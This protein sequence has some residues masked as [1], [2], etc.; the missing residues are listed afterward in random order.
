MT[1]KQISNPGQAF[2]AGAT[3]GTLSGDN[4]MTQEVAHLLNG[5]G[6]TLYT[7]DIVCMDATGTQAILST[8][9]G[10]PTQI[11]TVGGAEQWGSYYP[12]GSS[13]IN[14]GTIG[15]QAVPNLLSPNV[16]A[17]MGFTNG[18]ATVTYAGA[19]ATDLGKQLLPA[20]NSTTNAN[21]Q[22]LTIIAV[23]AGVNY[24]VSANFNGTTGTFSTLLQSPPSSIGPGW[25]PTSIA[26][27]EQVPVV[28]S[29]L[30]RVNINAVAATVAKD[31]ISVGNASVVGA[32]TA[33][34]A[35]VAGQIGQFIAVALEAYAARDTTLTGLGIAGHD[36]VRAI[37][38][39][40]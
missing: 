32:R 7:G 10:D 35:A 14:V 15:G 36:S 3:W 2:T 11:G 29:G 20:Y 5:T 22:V 8:S 21:P 25:L 38:G 12:V 39:K 31:F 30:G 9:A 33:N 40:F 1:N 24:T 28:K 34:G 37:I 19:A 13:A 6:Q 4:E 17:N 18:S 27:G 23:S 16:V 26:P